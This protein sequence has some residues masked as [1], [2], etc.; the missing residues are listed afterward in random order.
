MGG[1]MWH[2]LHELL[3]T[4]AIQLID[5]GLH[6]EATSPHSTLSTF[7][8]EHSTHIL[9]IIYDNPS[10]LDGLS[11]IFV[12]GVIIQCVQQ[13]ISN[14]YLNAVKATGIALMSVTLFSGW[15]WILW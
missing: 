2:F 12:V 3:S 6:S 10:E 5:R 8:A 1:L 11:Q 15:Q 14:Q 4:I 7:T 13:K 9:K